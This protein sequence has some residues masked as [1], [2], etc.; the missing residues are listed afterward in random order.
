MGV[1]PNCALGG[2]NC[3]WERPFRPLLGPQGSPSRVRELWDFSSVT[4]MEPEPKPCLSSESM[5]PGPP[6]NS[7]TSLKRKVYSE[8]ST[9][10]IYRAA[11]T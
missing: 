6:G 1:G 7:S 10:V 11:S 9:C 4:G 2:C 3:G 5:D 8:K